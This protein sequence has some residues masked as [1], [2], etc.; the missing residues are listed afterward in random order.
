V[1]SLSDGA[2]SPSELRRYVV[3]LAFRTG[4][5]AISWRWPRGDDCWAAAVATCLQVP[6]D[7]VPDPRI[8]ARLAQGA[9]PAEIDTS[10]QQEMKRW[11]K[12]RG[13]R[14]VFH[15]EVPPDLPRWLGVVPLAGEFNSHSMVMSHDKVLFDP[16]DEEAHERPVRT[17]PP[18]AVAWGVSFGVL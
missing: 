2:S 3:Q 8:D 12:S 16:V 6:I 10:A 4:P 14:M 7:E 1:S 5:S 13:L 17:F 18:D 9:T 15:R 11:L